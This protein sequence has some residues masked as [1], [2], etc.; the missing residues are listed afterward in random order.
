MINVSLEGIS[1]MP[2]QDTST[3]QLQ[4]AEEV[5]D[6]ILPAGDQTPG[7]VEP[8]EEALDPPAPSTAAERAAIL[9]PWPAAVALVCRNHL[10]PVP[11]AEQEV[12]RIAVVPP[13]ADQSRGELPEE[14]GVERGG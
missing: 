3:G 8:G 9:R 7:V 14:P 12:E 4:H 10:D 1:Y 5:L 13:I 2:E 11:V 6:V